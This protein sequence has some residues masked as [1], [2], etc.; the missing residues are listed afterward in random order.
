MGKFTTGCFSITAITPNIISAQRF[1]GPKWKNSAEASRICRSGKVCARS[2]ARTCSAFSILIYRDTLGGAAR[3]SART[4]LRRRDNCCSRLAVRG[5]EVCHVRC[6]SH[7]DAA[8]V[9]QSYC[10][11]FLWLLRTPHVTG[12]HRRRVAFPE[13]QYRRVCPR[14]VPFESDLSGRALSRQ[15]SRDISN[16]FQRVLSFVPR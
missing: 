14:S 7:R 9:S 2:S 8:T 3:L 11:T 12:E 4:L 15:S 13:N 6:A 16:R 1:T 5:A 10:A